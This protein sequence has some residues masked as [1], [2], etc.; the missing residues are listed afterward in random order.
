MTDFG[1]D[2]MIANG[3]IVWN[4]DEIVMVEGERNVIQQA[5]LRCQADLGE[6]LTFPEYGST[7]RGYQGKSFTS[8][9]KIAA[10]SEATQRL[11]MV[12]DGWI[13]EVLRCDVSLIEVDGKKKMLVQA[14]VKIRGVETPQD[15]DW[16]F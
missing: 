7:L 13:E 8:E 2:I 6:S 10:E 14:K 3:E 12:G 4:G 1:N 9:S 11:L 16:S 5:Y 15:M